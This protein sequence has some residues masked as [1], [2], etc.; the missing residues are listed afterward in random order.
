M[1]R[2]ADWVTMAAWLTELR[3]R[4]L[5]P[6]DDPH[7]TAAWDEA[8]ALRRRL[9]D[10]ALVRAAVAWLDAQPRFG[11]DVFARGGGQELGRAG[12]SARG[13]DLP[14]VLAVYARLLRAL[15]RRIEQAAQLYQ[16]RLL[17]LWRAR[18]ALAQIARLLPELLGTAGRAAGAGRAV[19]PARAGGPGRDA[20]GRA[21]PLGGDRPRARPPGPAQPRAGGRLRGRSRASA[22]RAAVV[23]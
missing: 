6:A 17:P 1:Q 2:L 10:R 12:A 13:A 18:D 4:L 19:R 5:L 7:A 14:A 16:P 23:L 9:A 3:S 15:A 21:A 11:R 22:T 8:K 20:R